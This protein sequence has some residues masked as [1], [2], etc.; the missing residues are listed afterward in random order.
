MMRKNSHGFF[1][2]FCFLLASKE[3]LVILFM[4]MEPSI[5][6]EF[7]VGVCVILTAAVI[8]KCAVEIAEL[9]KKKNF[10][11]YRAGTLPVPLNN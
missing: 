11:R 7:V 1:N 6:R 8:K 9:N 2:F 3:S 10:S 4:L 5:L